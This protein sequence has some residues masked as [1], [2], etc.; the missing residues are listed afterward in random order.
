MEMSMIVNERTVRD[1]GVYLDFHPQ[2]VEGNCLI[3]FI[4]PQ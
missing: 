2:I 1:Q 3:F 4:P